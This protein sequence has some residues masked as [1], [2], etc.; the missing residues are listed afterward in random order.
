MAMLHT[1]NKS[2]F[3][4]N[5]FDSCISMAKSGSSVL[6]IEDGVIASLKGTSVSDK[7]SKAMESVTFYVLG[8]D[9][10]ARGMTDDQ[11]IDGIKVVDYEGF[12]DLT[13]EHEN[14]QAWL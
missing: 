10:N 7:V 5:T 3:E 4:R 6:L 9:L 2:P 14:V 1:V 11:I 8:P 13:A 12:V